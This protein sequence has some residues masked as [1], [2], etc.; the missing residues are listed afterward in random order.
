MD[1]IS[2]FN[3]LILA[4][5]FMFILENF[6]DNMIRRNNKLLITFLKTLITTMKINN[7]AK[8]RMLYE[9]IAEYA[10][11]NNCTLSRGW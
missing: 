1:I 9:D 10:P 11:I 7:H 8:Y 3:D 5:G 2:I 6:I 4:I